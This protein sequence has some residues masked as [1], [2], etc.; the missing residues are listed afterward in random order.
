MKQ[1]RHFRVCQCCG[2]PV[3]DPE[4]AR[5]FKGN[6]REIFEIVARAGEAGITRERVAD[7]LY[8]DHADGGPL[9]AQGVVSTTISK[10]IN[11]RLAPYGLK[12]GSCQG[13]G[14]TPYR[15]MTLRASGH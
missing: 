4:L 3:T 12:I 5:L 1:P 13:R 14:G 11:P 2:F 10:W 7:H 8:A 9:Y 6:Q 15:L